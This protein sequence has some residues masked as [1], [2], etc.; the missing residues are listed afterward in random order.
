MIKNKNRNLFKYKNGKISTLKNWSGVFPI[1]YFFSKSK[2]FDCLRMNGNLY[3]VCAVISP[4][5]DFIRIL[6]ILGDV[7]MQVFSSNRYLEKKL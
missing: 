3:S 7:K 1:D 5:A 4:G 6:D 2:N